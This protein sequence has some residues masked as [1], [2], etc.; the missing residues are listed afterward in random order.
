MS[1]TK[2]IHILVHKEN[3]KKLDKIAKITYETRSTIVR[4]AINKYLS[5]FDFVKG[6]KQ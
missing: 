5:E 1:N 6:V 4:R 3:I 2:R